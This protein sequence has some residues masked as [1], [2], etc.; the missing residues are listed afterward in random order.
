MKHHIFIKLLGIIFLLS[1]CQKEVNVPVEDISF[2]MPANTHANGTEFQNVIDKYRKRGLVGVTLAIDD[3]VNG[4]WAG[5]SGMARL[6][7]RQ[8][9]TKY[10]IQRGGSIPKIY[11]GTAIML[12]YEEGLIDLDA[13][14]NTY[15]PKSICDNIT[16]GNKITIR[17]LLT[18]SSG[19]YEY[20]S[21]PQYYFDEMN[22]PGE[23]DYSP[24]ELIEFMYNKPAEFEPGE[25]T[26]YNDSNFLLLAVIIDHIINGNHAQYFKENIFDPNSLTHTYYKIQGGY[27]DIPGTANCYADW[28]GNGKYINISD[29]QNKWDVMVGDDGMY[30]STYDFLQFI[31]L[32]CEGQIVTQSSLDMMTDWIEFDDD[33]EDVSKVG[34]ALLHWQNKT[35]DNWGMG[36]GGSSQGMGGNVFYFPDR[37]I[38][39]ALFTNTDTE[40]GE[41]GKIFKELW[42]EIVEVAMK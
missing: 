24:L 19:L 28:Y 40:R 38:T 10:H 23:I 33:D 2:D 1:S 6:E 27:P 18:H 25:S 21:N 36:H 3:P 37:A 8:P 20:S 39:I 17:H 42:E 13:K 12:L 4:F 14:I 30:A 22:N 9:M 16:N 11:T 35:K 32:L 29:I 7:T 26:Y 34:L 5:A 31:K 41:G 15:L